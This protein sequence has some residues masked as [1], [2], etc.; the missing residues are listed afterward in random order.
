MQRLLPLCCCAQLPV[1]LLQSLK[2]ELLHHVSLQFHY[3]MF[4]LT[5]HKVI[6]FLP[7]TSIVTFCFEWFLIMMFLFWVVA[8]LISIRWN[9]IVLFVFLNSD[10]GHFSYSL[11]SFLFPLLKKWLLY[12]PIPHTYTCFLFFCF[13]WGEKGR[14]LLGWLGWPG[15]TSNFCHCPPRCWVY[16]HVLPCLCLHTCE[17]TWVCSIFPWEPSTFCWNRLLPITCH[18]LV[19]RGWLIHKLGICLP[20]ASWCWIKS[21]HCHVWF[22]C[23]FWDS[24]QVL[25]LVIIDRYFTTGWVVVVV[26]IFWI[27]ASSSWIAL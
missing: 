9:P 7:F 5:V 4:S 16:K 11:W 8:I 22:L 17:S 20:P 23:A 3:F 18:S 2:K 21:E 19:R 6:I 13:F 25:M 15:I 1:P 10:G 14:T 12:P 27:I 24:I 26:C